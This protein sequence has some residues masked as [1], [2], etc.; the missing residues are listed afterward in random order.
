MGDKRNEAVALLKAIVFILAG[1]IL[2]L[3]PALTLR[4][5]AMVFGAGVLAYG[6]F[7]AVSQLL[8]R[9]EK[10]PAALTAGLIAVVAGVVVLL[11]PQLVVGLF[12]VLAGILVI[13]GG[14]KRCTDALVAR[15]DGDRGW[16]LGMLLAMVC[17]GLGV[18]VILNPFGTAVNVVQLIGIAGIYYGVTALVRLLR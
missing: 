17:I 12:P 18:L 2:L 11:A 4:S 3:R 10:Q 13:L 6:I 5:A 14:V 8:A 15:S 7:T 9:D 1:V 16:P